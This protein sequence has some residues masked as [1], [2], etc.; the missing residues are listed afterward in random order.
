MFKILS[1]LQKSFFDFPLLTNPKESSLKI[2]RPPAEVTAIGERTS[3]NGKIVLDM[4]K[5]ITGFKT[6]NPIINV[7]LITYLFMVMKR[8]LTIQ[9]LKM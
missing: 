7:T 6:C 2:T 8:G 3:V 4:M 5:K 9:V 1:K